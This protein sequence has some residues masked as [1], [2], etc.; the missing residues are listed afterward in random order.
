MPIHHYDMSLAF[1]HISWLIHYKQ[2]LNVIKADIDLTAPFKAFKEV[3]PPMIQEDELILANTASRLRMIAL[4]ALAAKSG[5][6]VVGTGN[7]IED[8]GVGFFTKYGDGGVDIS[9][10]G[11]L[12]KSQVYKLAKKLEISLPIREAAPKDGL[13]KDNRTDEDQLGATYK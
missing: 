12:T 10:I 5:G 8:F 4:Y 13:W 3:L 7:K 11:D 1:K 9:P 2:Y 6:I